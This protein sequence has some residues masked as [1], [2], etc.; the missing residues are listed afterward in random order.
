MVEGPIRQPVLL[1]VILR[2]LKSEWAVC[3][4][5]LVAFRALIGWLA[6]LASIAIEHVDAV[7]I[8]IVALSSLRYQF[9]VQRGEHCLHIV[10]D[11]MHILECLRLE[12]ADVNLHL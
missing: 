7:A 4:P 11:C 9:Y 2:E 8:W 5:L 12:L 6:F 3:R 10:S 1:L